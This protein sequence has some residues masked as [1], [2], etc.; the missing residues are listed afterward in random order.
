MMV[1]DLG[2]GSGAIAIS[3]AE[4]R[5][6]WQILATDIIDETLNVAIQNAGTIQN[7]CFRKTS[8]FTDISE[9]FDLIVTIEENAVE[10]GFGAAVAS[11]LADR[12]RSGQRVVN[13]GVPDRFVEHG[14]RKMLLE[15]IG[16]SPEGIA[17]TILR[18]QEQRQERI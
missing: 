4:E 6:H 18:H 8:W 9:Q 10:G 2:T 11:H 15:E 14:P 1:I 3:L 17:R 12:L 13:L 5:P 7:L 16:L